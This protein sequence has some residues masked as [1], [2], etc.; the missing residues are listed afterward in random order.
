MKTRGRL[1]TFGLLLAT[2]ALATGC[3]TER[4]AGDPPVP[5]AAT[6]APITIDGLFDDWDDI[7]RA[8]VDVIGDGGGSGPD[9]TGIRLANDDRHLF[10]RLEA[11]AEFQLDEGHALTLCI[12]T[13]G[14]VATGEAIHGIGADL[15]WGLGE[16]TGR[17]HGSEGSVG[18]LPADIGFRAAPTVSSTTFELAI[19]R[20]AAPAGPLFGDGSL[21]IVVQDR[22][23]GEDG[24]IDGDLV[25]DSGALAYPFDPTPV[26]DPEPIPLER[27]SSDSIRVVTWNTL[28]DGMTDPDRAESFRRVL[29]ALDPDILALQEVTDHEQVIQLVP[30]ILPLAEGEWHVVS[31]GD[32]L[33][34]SR[35]PLV[36][37]W[38][39]S[40][41]PI[42]GRFTVSAVE[43]PD[44]RWLALFNAHMSCCEWE[45]DR[46]L[47]ADSFAAYL[48]DLTDPTHE[49]ALPEGTPM[50]LVGDLNL[51]QGSQPL[52]TLLTGEIVNTQW[53]GQGHPPDWDG[54][55]LADQVSRLTE[56]R[57][58]YTW[59]ADDGSYWPGRLDFVIHTDSVL[60]V[61]HSYVL[62]TVEMSESILDAHG[63]R[64]DDT[65]VASD[66]LPHVADVVVLDPTR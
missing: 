24:L 45:E 32:R 56:R 48:R 61:E 21:G 49:N 64:P 1:G 6:A 5:P 8:A 16:R 17:A 54:S 40:Y 11:T 33:T 36:T 37:E 59:R 10:V 43:L 12:D 62:H 7:P 9:L 28:W 26:G 60:S 27:Q 30:E 23:V 52:T 35:H 39:V 34:F 65:L 38:P 2:A 4:D 31:W 29:V 46:Q 51:V 47:E 22:S 55:P 13:D 53:Y 19:A 15:W 44:G 63:L 66:H 50:I 20:D 3:P 18:I 41:D 57:M 42:D 14:D 58:A 25:P